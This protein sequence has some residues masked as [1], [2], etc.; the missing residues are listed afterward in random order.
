[1][2]DQS[3]PEESPFDS[4]Y[5]IRQ[6][7][8]RYYDAQPVPFENADIDFY[9]EH[10]PSAEARVLELGS[11]TGRVLVPL[12]EHCSFIH[13][14]DL[15]PTMT[16]ICREKLAA[17]GFGK[18]RARA[19]VGDITNLDLD[20]RF[21][22]ITAPFRVFQNLE[23]DGQ[24]EGFFATVRRHLAPEGSAILNVFRPRAEP[25]ELIHSWTTARSELAKRF[26]IEMG[27]GRLE[28]YDWV[29][30]FTQEPLVCY[31]RILYR[32]VER[33]ETLDEAV[34]DIAMRCYYAQEFVEL[35]EGEGFQVLEKWGG[36]R[37]E[38]YGEGEEL[39]VRFGLK[40]GGG[41]THTDVCRH[42]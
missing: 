35:I 41:A 8:A 5:D 2:N 38:R 29:R 24:V 10:L 25:P 22:L 9:A 36:Y 27:P 34:L 30:G 39:V 17:D 14:V 7:A 31:P 42:G 20:A 21:D 16:A 4:S 28:G 3:S 6:N 33:G 37:G 11:G 1:M 12:A 15:S 19:D 18:E 40:T 32:Y 26:E 13:G 23:L